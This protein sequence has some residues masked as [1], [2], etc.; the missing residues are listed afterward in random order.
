MSSGTSIMTNSH[1]IDARKMIRTLVD[2]STVPS[3]RPPMKALSPLKGSHM[4]RS[5]MSMRIFMLMQI[6]SRSTDYCLG[7]LSYLLPLLLRV[8][9]LAR[10]CCHRGGSDGRRWPTC[11][12]GRS[13]RSRCSA[14]HPT[15][16]LLCH[17][18]HDDQQCPVIPDDVTRG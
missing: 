4:D 2:M 15:H 6:S 12:R 9:T 16:D 17:H 18:G 5:S 1:I 3:L 11:R 7:S 13:S 10:S 8:Y 14:V